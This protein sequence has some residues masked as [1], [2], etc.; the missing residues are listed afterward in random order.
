MKT[1]NLLLLGALFA[2]AG[3]G[4]HNIREGGLCASNGDC[5][6]PLVCSAGTCVRQHFSS[7]HKCE[8]DADCMGT[9]RCIDRKCQ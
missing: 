2:L 1:M 6:K 5:S 7:G 9:N 3:C 8:V 4:A